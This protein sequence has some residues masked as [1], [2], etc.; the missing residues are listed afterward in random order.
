MVFA[1]NAIAIMA[2]IPS[3]EIGGP[4]IINLIFAPLVGALGGALMGIPY[5]SFSI[6]KLAQRY[7]EKYT[8]LKIWGISAIGMMCMLAIRWW[9]IP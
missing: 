8:A 4:S 7:N 9:L 6:S 2:I 1:G 3:W 5:I